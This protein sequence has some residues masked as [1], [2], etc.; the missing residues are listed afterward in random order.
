VLLLKPISGNV[1]VTYRSNNLSDI[2]VLSEKFSVGQEPCSKP[3]GQ[4]ILSEAKKLL[5]LHAK[6]EENRRAAILPI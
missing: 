6:H 2:V 3:E 5:T 4:R 1:T